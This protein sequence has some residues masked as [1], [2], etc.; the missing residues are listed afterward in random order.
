[1]S[2]K[3]RYHFDH[4]S[5][6]FERVKGSFKEKLKSVSY[7][8]ALGVVLA[9][10][11]LV[12][13]YNFID[14]PKE[15][16]LKRE[17][18]QYE[19][20]YSLLSK[21]LA[22]LET[23]LKDLQNRDDNIYR[24]IFESEPIPSSV[25][26]AGI[27]GA[28]R[29]DALKGFDNSRI[30][31]ET[32]QKIDKVS[33]QMYIQSK[34]LDEIFGIAKKKYERMACM[35]A[36]LPVSKK[37][38]KIMSGFGERFHPIL[39]YMRPHTGI[40]IAAPTGSY[41]YATADGVITTAGRGGDGYGICCIINHGFGYQTLYG[42]MSEILVRENQKIKRGEIIG[43]VGSS[44]LSSAPHLHYEVIQNGKKVNPIYF[45]FNDLSPEEYEEVLEKSREENQCL[46]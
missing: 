17:I 27:G 44:G 25:R 19:R 29:Y 33:R 5:M 7:S 31:T 40:D 15:K 32:S 3:N 22:N 34:S 46:S 13:G 39:K 10:V 26:N 43:K 1:M 2:K 37:Q 35:P 14:S 11:I 20:Q 9:T 42:H 6:R 41:I 38:G 23:V 16:N 18:K 30:I 8:V 28:E 45:F 24:V 21:R 36:I 12:L 4:H